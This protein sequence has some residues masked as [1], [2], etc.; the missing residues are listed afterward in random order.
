LERPSRIGLKSKLVSLMPSVLQNTATKKQLPSASPTGCFKVT[1]T[2]MVTF[3]SQ[4]IKTDTVVL[5]QLD[6]NQT[7]KITLR[8]KN[9]LLK[10]SLITPKMNFIRL[11]KKSLTSPK[12]ISKREFRP[13]E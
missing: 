1:F 5:K 7:L 12:K 10:P 3:I 2:G 8:N 11:S 4:T 13:I 9:K 6:V